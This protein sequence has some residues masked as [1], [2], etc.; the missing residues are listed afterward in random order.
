MSTLQSFY[1]YAKL[2]I[3]IFI[4][5]G[6]PRNLSQSFQQRITGC[7]GVVYRTVW[8]V[9]SP[10]DLTVTVIFPGPVLRTIAEAFP[11][12]AGS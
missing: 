6:K 3:K 8:A 7:F 12:K 9:L 2:I 5:N 4:N 11:W 10:L 1:D